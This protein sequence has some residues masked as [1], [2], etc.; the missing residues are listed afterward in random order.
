MLAAR[1]V[2]Q[3]RRQRQHDERDDEDDRE[4]E[5]D[6]GAL[7]ACQAVDRERKSSAGHG[8]QAAMVSSSAVPRQALP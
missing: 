3:H 8:V 1:Q 2:E 7:A 4:R 5:R 6:F